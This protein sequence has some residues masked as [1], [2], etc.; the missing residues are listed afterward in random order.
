[1]LRN[2]IINNILRLTKSATH[3]NS[4]PVQRFV[5]S[6]SGGTHSSD[7]GT[8]V[9]VVAAIGAAAIAGGYAKYRSNLQLDSGVDVNEE[10]RIDPDGGVSGA[11]GSKKTGEVSKINPKEDLRAEGWIRN[12]GEK[13]KAYITMEE[14]ARHD[15]AQDAWVVVEGKVFDVSN[16]HKYHPGGSQIIVANAGKDVTELFKPVHPPK[17]LENNLSPECYKGMVDPRAV[18]DSLKAYEAEQERIERERNALAPVET[19]LGLDELQEAAESF[20]SPRVIN[21]YGASSLDGYSLAEN[22]SSFRKCRLVPRVM[23]DVTKVRPQTTIFGVPSALPIYISPASNALL[24]HPDGEL[25]IVRGASKTGIVQGISAAASFPL[26]E[27]LEEKSKMDQEG[28]N[29]MGM[30][31]QVYLSRDRQKNVEQLKEVVEGGCQALLLTVDSNVG[32]HRQSTEKLKGAKGNAEPGTR[33]GPIEN[34]HQWHDASQNWEDLKFIKELAPGLPI[35]LKGVSHIEDVRLAKEYGLA[36]C[37][38]SNHG[39]RQLDGARTG[40]DSLRSIYAQDPQLVKDVE[41]Y[42]DGGVRR[43]HEVL[44]ALAFGAKGVGLGRPFLWAQAA[45][46]EK[47]VIRAV[48]ILEREIVTAMQL[49]GV[50]DLSQ[51]KPDMV[52]CLQ[53]IW[54]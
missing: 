47:G 53:E 2:N 45:Y 52:E 31:Y 10:Q 41:I 4:F 21:Y 46:G 34:D 44:Q 26:S 14:V 40:F 11:K 17:T 37:I 43:G 15:L 51:I 35:Y 18:A 6:P 13:E 49:M 20:L 50:T 38:L 23:R 22:R 54:K 25:N 28:G 5:H 32:D 12:G 8:K 42:I 3:K 9:Y 7:N 1:M 16:F 27:I 48:R 36:G 30:V 29:K 33:M 24:G 19:M 39:G